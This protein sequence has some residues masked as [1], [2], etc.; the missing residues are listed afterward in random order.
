MFSTYD[1]AIKGDT[2]KSRCMERRWCRMRDWR[3][4]DNPWRLSRSQN[5]RSGVRPLACG[6]RR[7]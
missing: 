4:P 7:R 3:F 6:D 1:C 5:R 2:S